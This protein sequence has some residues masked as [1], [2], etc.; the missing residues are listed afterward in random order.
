MNLPPPVIELPEESPLRAILARAE[1]DIR[2]RFKSL[3]RGGDR[4]LTLS[5]DVR[6]REGSPLGN[7]VELKEI[8]RDHVVLSVDGYEYQVWISR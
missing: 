4:V 7:G 5:G 1:A 3:T 8:N 2:N 6:L